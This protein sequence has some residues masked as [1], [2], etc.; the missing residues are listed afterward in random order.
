MHEWLEMNEFYLN[1]SVFEEVFFLHHEKISYRPI[2]AQD[3]N[4][5]N[6]RKNVSILVVHK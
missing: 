6:S 3:K 1:F 4:R 2:N 5:I